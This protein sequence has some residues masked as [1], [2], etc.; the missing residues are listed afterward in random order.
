M[1][2]WLL[3]PASLLAGYLVGSISFAVLLARM[4]GVDIFTIG[5]GNPG[6]TNVMRAC[7]K[8][9]GYACFLLD[10]CKG[11]ASVLIAY[12]LAGDSADGAKLA[13][14]VA[15]MGA[16]LGHSF[17]VFL[18]FRGGKGVATTV[19]GLFALLPYVMLMGAVVWLVVF[20]ISRYVSL[21]SLALGLSLPLSAL[22]LYPDPRAVGFCLFLCVL[23]F[24]RHRSNIQR[25]MAGT[26]NRAGS[27]K[28]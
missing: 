14:I 1:D 12:G 20:F 3:L 24:V 17:S 27:R 26:E 9:I 18:R 25:L 6:A 22:I 5:S 16:I 19:G 21:A 2:L 4:R 7:G 15:L 8:P 13:G 28:Q 11:I 10:A 23:I